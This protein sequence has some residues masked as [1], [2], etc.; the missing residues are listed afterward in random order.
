ML[1]NPLVSGIM[2]VYNGAEFVGCALESIL[3]QTYRNIEV[4]VVNDGSTDATQ[5]ILE[6]YAARD[7]RITV[8]HQENGGVARARNRAIAE[9]TSEFIAPI[10]AYDIWS[11]DKIS[12]QLSRML[13]VGDSVGM[14]YSWWAWIGP[15]GEVLDRSPRWTIEGTVF[16]RLVAINFVGN[17]SVKRWG[18]TTKNWRPRRPVD[19]KTGRWR[20]MSRRS[21]ASRWR[22]R[23]WWDIA[24]VLEA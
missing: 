11:P 12:R 8:V 10:D 16:E 15:A 24:G 20:C 22:R 1:S 3:L 13:A 4:I 14:V 6:G 19:V 21:I 9:S 18:D 23:Y 7:P 2:P 5:E 17:A